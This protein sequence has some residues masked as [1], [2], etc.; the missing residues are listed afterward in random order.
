MR[1]Y[2]PRSSATGLLLPLIILAT[3]TH[4]Q[5]YR[6]KGA[7]YATSVF[8]EN[9]A[10]YVLG[11]YIYGTDTPA[12]Q[13]FSLDLST[14]WSIHN[15][16]YTQLPSMV[17]GV[18]IPSTL[19]DNEIWYVIAGGRGAGGAVYEYN[20][21]SQNWQT[22]GSQSNIT[23]AGMSA[24]YNPIAR[25]VYIPNGSKQTTTDPYSILIYDY[26]T[27]AYYHSDMPPAMSNITNYSA[28]WAPS[29]QSVLVFGGNIIT[30]WDTNNELYAYHATN[31]W[32]NLVTRGAIPPKR[33]MACF[34]PAYSGSKMILFGGTTSGSDPSKN[35]VIY[36]DIY[37]LDVD[38]LTW[39][40]GTNAPAVVI[41]IYGHN[42]AYSNDQLIVWGGYPLQ[43]TTNDAFVY[44]LKTST[45]TD[46]FVALK[47]S[48]SATTAATPKPTQGNQP[49]I[50]ENGGNS[51]N[52]QGGG[53]SSLIPII[54]GVVGGFVLLVAI[55]GFIIYRRKS[56]KQ[57]HEEPEH[58]PIE[59]LPKAPQFQ[60]Q[61]EN[62]SEPV[63]NPY[64][65]SPE[66][67]S[68]PSSVVADS[69]IQSTYEVSPIPNEWS[70][71][72]LSFNSTNT[73]NPQASTTKTDSV[74]G[75]SPVVQGPQLYYQNDS[76]N[77]FIY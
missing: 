11:G 18:L 61:Y 34:V 16:I 29:I 70:E 75:S 32:R 59:H 74:V 54:A 10:M 55:V 12:G 69:R 48:Q 72:R 53:K 38:T 3:S 6:A 51:E 50:N 68:Q 25:R 73:R 49:D 45:W 23:G 47:D 27:K 67:A 4:A 8:I 7:G 39:T 37:I 76:N 71:N 63:H 77:Y 14:T 52:Y 19:I 57:T 13:T 66:Y 28:T 26:P 56:K 9:K 41:G 15:P 20:I 36:G 58:K 1:L 64:S 40:Q 2:Y 46:N 21:T 17:T 44:N 43:A 60:P 33:T 65:M 62:K 35:G 31:G 42:C 30:T 5:S 24:V 22:L